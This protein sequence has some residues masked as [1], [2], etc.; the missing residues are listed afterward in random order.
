MVIYMYGKAV[1]CNCL[2]ISSMALT[3]AGFLSFSITNNSNW[4]LQSTHAGKKSQRA[5]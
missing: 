3:A 1:A 5:M 4:S 2:P